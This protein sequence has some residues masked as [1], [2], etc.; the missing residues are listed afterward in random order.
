MDSLLE[1]LKY[2]LPSLV[3]F[4]TAYY[5][6]REFI[7]L[8][9]KKKQLELRAEQHKVSLPIRLQA[10][11]RIVLLLERISPQ[12]L[13]ARC[14][15]ADMKVS[16]MQALLVQSIRDEFDHNLSQQLYVS[17]KAWEMVKN[18]REEMIKEIH[19][20]AASL[21]EEASATD[22]AQIILTKSAEKVPT[23]TA[24]EFIKSEARQLF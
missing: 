17:E 16:V 9:Q 14:H 24:I 8:D 11:E 20:S 10:Y 18:A 6:L 19:T 13:V 2:V 1:I 12:S 7:N 23:R 5:I 21:G 3:V 4:A 22:L 15:K